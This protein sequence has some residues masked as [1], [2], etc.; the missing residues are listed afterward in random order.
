MLTNAVAQNNMDNLNRFQIYK[1]NQQQYVAQLNKI[2]GQLSS[3]IAKDNRNGHLGIEDLQN[4]LSRNGDTSVLMNKTLAA[5]ER[6]S[7]AVDDRKAAQ[8]ALNSKRQELKE[9]NEARKN[10]NQ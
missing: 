2:N 7:S 8:E 3:A 6:Y 4:V 1:N 10:L 5:Y 9:C